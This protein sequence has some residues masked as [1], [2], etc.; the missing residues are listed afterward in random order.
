LFWRGEE[1]IYEDGLPL[2]AHPMP[3][4]HELRFVCVLA[5][6]LTLVLHGA[7]AAPSNVV[8]KPVS[9]TSVRQGNF[10]QHWHMLLQNVTD[11]VGSEV[12]WIAIGSIGAI[13]TLAFIYLQIRTS[14]T[15][16]S[17]ELLLKLEDQF[18]SATMRKHRKKLMTV[19]KKDPRDYH[20]INEEILD[21]FEDIGFLTKKKV[22]SVELVWSTYCYWILR[23]YLLL[24][25]Y[26]GWLRKRDDD[27]TY[28]RDFEHLYRENLKMEENRRGRKI[29]ITPQQLQGFIDEELQV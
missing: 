20:N 15:I 29:E 23:Y 17:A 12:F 8:W 21:F 16:A 18:Y 9:T 5:V 1:V 24:Q 22:L 28:Y 2:L 27:T 3:R 6:L 4:R 11:L 14:K 19:L 25:E 13:S 10:T 26:I 7:N